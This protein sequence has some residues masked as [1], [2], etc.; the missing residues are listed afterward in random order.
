MV[1]NIYKFPIFSAGKPTYGVRY[2]LNDFEH[3]LY[4]D[5]HRF[6]KNTTPHCTHIKILAYVKFPWVINRLYLSLMPVI[7]K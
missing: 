7:E 5:L 6:T 2:L 4:L 3:A 1:K